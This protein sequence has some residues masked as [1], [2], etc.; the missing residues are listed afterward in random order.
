M[1]SL[2]CKR[3]TATSPSTKII[4]YI[5]WKKYGEGP[6]WT[7]AKLHRTC[8]R[9]EESYYRTHQKEWKNT[10][11]HSSRGVYNWC[12]PERLTNALS[13]FRFGLCGY[14]WPVRVRQSACTPRNFFP[15]S[16]TYLS[17]WKLLTIFR[18]IVSHIMIGDYYWWVSVT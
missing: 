3:S 9:A 14:A 8:S 4:T 2:G 7:A 1:C 6:A 10:T 12:L 18:K 15:C 5:H 16:Y 13:W 11:S 17:F